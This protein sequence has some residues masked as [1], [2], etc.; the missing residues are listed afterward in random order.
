MGMSPVSSQICTMRS[1][2]PRYPG[3]LAWQLNLTRKDIRRE[4]IYWRMHQ[5]LISETETGSISR[6]ETVSMI[7]PLLLNVQ[8]SHKVFRFILGLHRVSILP[9]VLGVFLHFTVH[10]VVRSAYRTGYTGLFLML[11]HVVYV[12]YMFQSKYLF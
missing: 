12:T 11:Y 2:V 1:S 5:F 3:G 4:E 7:P 9:L 8:P 10:N 6:Q